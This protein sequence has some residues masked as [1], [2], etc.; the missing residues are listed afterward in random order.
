M[1][2]EMSVCLSVCRS[3]QQFYVLPETPSF[4][5]SFFLYLNKYASAYANIL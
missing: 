3:A 5:L 1:E 2:I 4:A